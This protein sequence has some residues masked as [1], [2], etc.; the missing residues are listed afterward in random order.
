MNSSLALF[1]LKLC[2]WRVEGSLPDSI[3][4]A[5]VVMAPHTS[6]WDFVLGWL[7]FSALGLKSMY[8]IKKEAFFFPI[9]P[10]VK[11]LG[12]I[13]VDRGK[14][15]V[16]IQIGELFLE[17]KELIITVTPEGTRSLNHTWKKGFYLI[18]QHAQ[19]PLVFGYL[20]YKNKIGG[21]GP[22]F[23]V[24]GDYEKDME[25]IENFYKQKTAKFPGLYN[26]SP[27]NLGKQ[28]NSY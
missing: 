9:G 11:K 2:G 27:E 12:G 10:L 26:L 22:V 15:K 8:L 28:D 5:V 3:K 7:G 24:T 14:N 23:K 16:V 4:R 17:S 21:L 13:P 18:A 1:I 19:V 6:N 25:V 20:D